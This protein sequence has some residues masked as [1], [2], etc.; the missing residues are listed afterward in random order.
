MQPDAADAALIDAIYETPLDFGRWA[1]VLDQLR[2]RAGS[3]GAALTAGTSISGTVVT[4]V[5]H[6]E[7]SAA[8]YNGHFHLLDP[9]IPYGMRQQAG[10]W[11]NDWR[12]LGQRFSRTEYYN[13]FFLRH[14]WQSCSARILE[15]SPAAW[16]CVSFQ[17]AEGAAPMSPADERALDRLMQHTARA[18]RLQRRLEPLRAEAD[19]A[20]AALDCL[21]LAVWVVDSRGRIVL[22][23]G[24]AQELMSDAGPMRCKGGALVAA[25]GGGDRLSKA[26]RRATADDGAV[27]SWVQIDGAAGARLASVLPLGGASSS[28]QA[29]GGRLAV[30]VIQPG[31]AP[32]SIEAALGAVYGL[33]MRE[34]QVCSLV[35]AGLQVKEVADRL[36]L[37]T[38][39]VRKVL[40]SVFGKVG[41]R[42]QAELVKTVAQ[43]QVCLRDSARPASPLSAR[44]RVGVRA[45]EGRAALQHE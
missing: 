6:S 5:G 14:G 35:S 44:H 9:L 15:M 17:W 11:L 12:L 31:A 21:T 3:Q 36:R 22:A 19:I 4:A 39:T 45:V 2:V 24:A 42:R 33:S 18:L 43:L 27:A 1:G 40:K 28:I 23:N 13:D 25:S 30:V 29:S 10:T 41:V 32:A 34:R 37:A 16:A 20:V 8:D 38:E 7:A 26:L